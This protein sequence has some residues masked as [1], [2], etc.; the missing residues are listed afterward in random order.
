MGF[1]TL[2]DIL[3]SV[4]IGGLL[5]MILL[6]LNDA[7]VRNS[8]IYNG[9]AILQENLVEV[10]KLIEFDFRQMGYTS[11]WANADPSAPAI[12]SAD[13]TSISFLVDGSVINYFVGPT[14][15]LLNTPNPNDKILYRSVNGG[16]PLSSNMGITKFDLSYYKIFGDTL[17][18]P[19]PTNKLGEIETI[20]IDIEIED[21]YGYDTTYAKTAWRQIRMSSRN[22]NKR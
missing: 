20:Q 1:S 8:Y 11:D 15:E 21:V 9:D 3:G 10:V 12:T 2:L 6:S 13:S 14:S 17:A 16:T 19:V 18:M 5:L 4:V 22:R 7:A